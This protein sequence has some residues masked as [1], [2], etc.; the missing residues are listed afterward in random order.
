MSKE[1]VIK[2][3]GK[4]TEVLPNTMFR[5][6]LANMDTIILATVSGRMRKHGIKVLLGDQV[7]IE[8]SP[9]DLE[10]GRISRRN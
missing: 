4:V 2:V 5:V 9:Y 6:Q 7:S 1:E 10:R 8:M 3:D